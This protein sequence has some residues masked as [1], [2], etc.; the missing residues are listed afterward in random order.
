M[1]ECPS[2]ESSPHLPPSEENPKLEVVCKRG[3]QAD[4]DP[5]W[6]DQGL[7]CRKIIVTPDPSVIDRLSLLEPIAS[8]V[9]A[10][11]R[12]DA[13]SEVWRKVVEHE[14]VCI[15]L[16]CGTHPLMNDVLGSIYYSTNCN[17]CA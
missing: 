1:D 5:R 17:R 8:S 11:E 7:I 13:D 14:P 15:Q 4:A 3:V 9:D 10:E 2:K 16:N 12:E 6:E